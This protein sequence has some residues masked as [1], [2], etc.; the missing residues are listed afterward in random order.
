[1][2][3]TVKLDQPTTIPIMMMTIVIAMMR[4]RY[5]IV[6]VVIRNHDPVATPKQVPASGV[7][8][9]SRKNDKP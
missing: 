6:V 4:L 3:M 8:A 1:M 7:V 9:M 2:T 5:M